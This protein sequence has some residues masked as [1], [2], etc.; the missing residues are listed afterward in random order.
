MYK[1]NHFLVSKIRAQLIQQLADDTGP[2]QIYWYWHTV[3][4][5]A[6]I[7]KLLLRLEKMLGPVI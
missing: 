4:K 3:R 7:L 2:T 1:N 5:Y 6:T